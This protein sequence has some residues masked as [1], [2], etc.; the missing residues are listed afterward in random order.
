M[1]RTMAACDCHSSDVCQRRVGVGGNIDISIACRLH[2]AVLY[3]P[4][5][6]G[7]SSDLCPLRQTCVQHETSLLVRAPVN[8]VVTTCKCAMIAPCLHGNDCALSV[9]PC[10]RAHVSI[11][12][13]RTQGVRINV[14]SRWCQFCSRGCRALVRVCVDCISSPAAS[15]SGWGPGS[16]RQP[17]DLMPRLWSVRKAHFALVHDR[18]MPS[19]SSSARACWHRRRLVGSGG[20]HRVGHH[21]LL[22]LRRSGS[23]LLSGVVFGAL[24]LRSI[25]R[26]RSSQL[27]AQRQRVEY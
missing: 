23:P 25:S 10:V 16:E 22:V 15:K 8:C 21:G 9:N 24:L 17:G 20:P 27:G 12:A 5:A 26:P 19:R 18:G 3:C 7:D 14:L 11:L 1:F 4:G 6:M 2:V 13:V